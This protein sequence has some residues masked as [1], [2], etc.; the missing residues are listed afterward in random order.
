MLKHTKTNG[1]APS[2]GVRVVPPGF[3]RHGRSGSARRARAATASSQA[4]ARLDPSPR[5][6]P[7]PAPNP[8]EAFYAA[9]S[10]GVGLLD[11]G[12][13]DLDEDPLVLIGLSA[14]RGYGRWET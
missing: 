10:E 2:S 3:G 8:Y 6:A 5:A 13:D 7:L 14:S 12:F 1:A 4:R 11:P 9:V